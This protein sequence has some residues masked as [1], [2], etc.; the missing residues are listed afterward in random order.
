MKIKQSGQLIYSF[1]SYSPVKHPNTAPINAPIYY[2]YLF[3]LEAYGRVLRQGIMEFMK[4]IYE[5]QCNR[6][7]ES[8][9]LKVD[10]QN[11]LIYLI[12]DSDY[13]DS[14]I[15][16]PELDELAEEGDLVELC[17]RGVAD[18]AVL[19]KENFL[20][21]LLKWE[22]IV[23]TSDSFLL[24]YLDDKNW[25]DSEPF[26]SLQAM[27]KFIAD[28]TDNSQENIQITSNNIVKNE[29]H[30][31]SIIKI[32]TILLVAVTFLVRLMNFKK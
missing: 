8:F 25:Y 18:H 28:H 5:S 3:L 12:E 2:L 14:K 1:G 31:M 20:Y 19:T 22:K 32:L 13:Y 29:T 23:Q 24:L 30:K 6:L 21:L 27:E 9:A 11:N 16:T 15:N 17:R 7:Y 4:E 26:D 10:T